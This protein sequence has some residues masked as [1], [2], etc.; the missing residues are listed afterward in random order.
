M[1][2]S[3]TLKKRK[4]R[5]EK[6]RNRKKQLLLKSAQNWTEIISLFHTAGKKFILFCYVNLRKIIFKI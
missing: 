3:H 4:G 1:N 2:N 6:E 5:A